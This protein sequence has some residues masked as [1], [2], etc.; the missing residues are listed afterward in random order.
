ME[1]AYNVIFFLLL[2]F[3][4]NRYIIKSCN[5]S[6][7][8]ISINYKNAAI[9]ISIFFIIDLIVRTHLLQ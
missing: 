6:G 7:G 4:T 2:F 1:I 9:I 8:N 3:I 5:C